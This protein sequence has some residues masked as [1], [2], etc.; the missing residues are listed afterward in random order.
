MNHRPLVVTGPIG[1][2][3]S[4]VSKLLESFGAV[5]ADLDLLS[6]EV[7]TSPAG[8]QFVRGRWPEVV[9]AAGVDRAHLAQI[10]FADPTE[11]RL[12]E[13]FVHP[14]VMSTFKS[15]FE[16]ASALVVE[17]S[18]PFSIQ[19][20]GGYVLLVDTP[21]KMRFERLRERGMSGD[22]IDA[23]MTVQPERGQWLETA[24]AVISN[25]LTAED[26]ARDAKVLW[27]RWSEARL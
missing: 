7:L 3:K 5:R 23:R 8:I 24:D 22:D 25:R 4:T 20:P 17:V 16:G 2:G 15:R 26:L 19:I 27:A 12:L 11:L 18:V 9:G 10:V 1:S 21:K 13:E 6:A 14:L